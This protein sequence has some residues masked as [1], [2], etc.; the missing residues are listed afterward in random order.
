MKTLKFIL[1]VIGFVL[2]V[3]SMNFPCNHEEHCKTLREHRDKD[4]LKPGN[5]LH[6]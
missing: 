3:T 4:R 5:G 6:Y 2:L 1:A